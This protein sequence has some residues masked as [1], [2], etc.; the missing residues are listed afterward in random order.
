LKECF[1]ELP[2]VSSKAGK[3]VSQSRPG[4]MGRGKVERNLGELRSYN[5]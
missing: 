5:L 2:F 3:D 4:R 1:K